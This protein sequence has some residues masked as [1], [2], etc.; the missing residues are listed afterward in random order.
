MT[1]VDI[2]LASGHESAAM[3]LKTAAASSPGEPYPSS[4]GR[5]HG[6]SRKSHKPA[7]SERQ[8]GKPPRMETS[9]QGHGRFLNL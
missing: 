2:A 3:L 1:P 8:R 7:I 5:T 4:N 6:S 9:L